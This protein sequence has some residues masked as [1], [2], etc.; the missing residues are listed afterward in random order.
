MY[1]NGW[2][3]PYPLKDKYLVGKNWKLGGVK[4]KQSN[5]GGTGRRGKKR[6]KTYN[7]YGAGR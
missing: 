3:D 7:W 4:R 5:S 1:S 6:G 2:P